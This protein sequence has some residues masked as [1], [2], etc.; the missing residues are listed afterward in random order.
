MV[1]ALIRLIKRE[2]PRWFNSSIMMLKVKIKFSNA[3]ISGKS[4]FQL[5]DIDNLHIGDKTLISAFTFITIANDELSMYN[6]SSI[7]IGHSTYIGENNNI[8]AGGGRIEI[9]NY[10]SISQHITIVASNHTIRKNDLIQN[11]RWDTN[12]NFVII[13]DDVWIGANSVILPGVKIHRG[14]VIGAGSVVTKD[15]PE[16]AIAYGNPARV[17]KYRL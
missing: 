6:N 17:I 14:A 8:R 5:N 12:N 13:E 16:N 3:D 11:Q 2:L 15:I 1:L 4:L 10:C 7:S 9:G